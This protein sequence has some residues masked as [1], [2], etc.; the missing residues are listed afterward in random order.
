MEQLLT[1][2]KQLKLQK[3][4]LKNYCKMKLTERTMKV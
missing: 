3:K 4:K 2:E 1:K